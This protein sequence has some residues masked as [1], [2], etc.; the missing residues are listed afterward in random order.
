MSQLRRRPCSK[1]PS[2]RRLH[3]ILMGDLRPF[4][5]TVRRISFQPFELEHAILDI[6]IRYRPIAICIRKAFERLRGTAVFS[7]HSDFI[8]HYS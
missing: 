7:R 4:F 1:C 5:R 8:N 2:S 6:A 3:C